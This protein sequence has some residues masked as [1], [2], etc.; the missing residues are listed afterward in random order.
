MEKNKELGKLQ[1]FK[2]K[3]NKEA[4]FF[5]GWLASS[6]LIGTSRKEDLQDLFQRKRKDRS[7]TK[8]QKRQIC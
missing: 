6:S 7:T 8:L 1:L 4:C 2:K 5:S 3:A